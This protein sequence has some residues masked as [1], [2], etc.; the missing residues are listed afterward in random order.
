MARRNVLRHIL[1]WT[2]SAG[3][4]CM[5]LCGVCL[6]WI[7]PRVSWNMRYG[8]SIA[9]HQATLSAARRAMH[10]GDIPRT[11][12]LEKWLVRESRVALGEST[13]DY[14]VMLKYCRAGSGLE[15]A[16]IAWADEQRIVR[17][18]LCVQQQDESQKSNAP[19]GALAIPATIEAFSQAVAAQGF[20]KCCHAGL[21]NIEARW[22]GIP[23]YDVPSVC[24]YE[25][26]LSGDMWLYWET[27]RKGTILAHGVHDSP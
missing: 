1:V 24:Y 12:P 7:G 23:A 6:F 5:S 26:R 4:V 19:T 17:R 9:R 27:D 13:H 10:I 15:Y 16:V 22:Y 20:V 21:L 14:A 2:L 3:I 25:A 8:D 18:Y 11:L